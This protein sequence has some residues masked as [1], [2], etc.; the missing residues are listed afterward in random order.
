[1]EKHTTDS[2]NSSGRRQGEF[3]ELKAE[4]KKRKVQIPKDSRLGDSLEK[5]LVT[6][7]ISRFA[8][9]EAI[10]LIKA[11]KFGWKLW[12][13]EKDQNSGFF[14]V[15]GLFHEG[16]RNF[17][18]D[19]GIQKRYISKDTSVTIRSGNGII[20]E[21]STTE[22]KDEIRRYVDSLPKEAAVKYGKVSF[23]ITRDALSNVVLKQL[24]NLANNLWLENLVI[25]D[26]PLLEDNSDAMY[27]VYLNCIAEVK[28]Q[29]IQLKPLA[30]F[31]DYC[32]WKRRQIQRDFY[33]AE[34][35]NLGEFFKFCSNVTANEKEKFLALQTA[36]GHLLHN[37]RPPTTTQAII[38]YDEAITTSERPQGGTGKGLIANSIRQMRDVVKIDGKQYQSK[39]KFKY[40]SISPSTQVVWIDDPSGGYDMDDLFSCLTDGWNIESKYLKT[41][42]IP[43]E[44]SPNVLICSNIILPHEGTS[45]ERRQFIIELNDYYSKKIKPGRISPVEEEHGLL[46]SKDWSQADWSRF[47]SF[48]VNCGMLYLLHGLYA[49]PPKNVKLN[50]LRKEIKIPE[51]FEYIQANP[52]IANEEFEIKSRFEVFLKDYLSEDP[53]FKQRTFTG[54]LKKYASSID[55]V[56]SSFKS[57]GKTFWCLKVHK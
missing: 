45:R 25:H 11:K 3:T 50:Y 6:N 29:G 7:Q 23:K 18:S 27:F 28:R 53:T 54:F 36:I 42:F 30:D 13:F 31:Q 22:I 24:N 26:K 55:G 1:M 35:Y 46:F 17:F 48:M 41:F 37:F 44:D 47:D 38:L 19:R 34:D 21:I 56:L 49:C 57:N 14:E 52:L 32:V 20:E 43:H 33:P 12:E 10:E 5:S 2:P 39:D 8:E 9:E 51:F 4:L 40:Q 16:I 15:K